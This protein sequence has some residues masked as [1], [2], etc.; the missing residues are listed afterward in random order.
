[1]TILCFGNITV[2][3]ISDIISI[4]TPITLLTW[5]YYSQKQKFAK[6]YFNE[7][8]GIY[9]G[10]TEPIHQA[11]K[12]SRVYSGIIMN[13]RDTNENGYFKGEFDFAETITSSMGDIKARDGIHMFLGKLDFSIY[14]NTKRHPFKP[15]ENRT[16]VGALYIVDRLDFAFES[17][18]IE[19]YLTAE[20]D[21]L[22]Y[23]EMQTLKFTLKKI[24]RKDIPKLPDTFILYKKMGFSFEPYSSLKQTVF[25]DGTRADR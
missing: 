3:D 23:R 19:T 20:Y 7:I 4:L 21:I 10:F 18:Q 11:D 22:H 2:K 24:H 16:Y 5:F 14:R 1:M 8:D 15:H 25:M 13:I 6:E 17:Y 9:A 12:G